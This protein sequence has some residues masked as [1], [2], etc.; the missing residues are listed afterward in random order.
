MT[1]WTV[2]KTEMACE[3]RVLQALAKLGVESF[4]PQKITPVRISRH[5]RKATYTESP[6]IARYIF[7]QCHPDDV[8]SVRYSEGP[9]RA[10]SGLA[11]SFPSK[12]ME[13]FQEAHGAWIEQQLMPF[14]VAKAKAMKP[15]PIRAEIV[16]GKSVSPFQQLADLFERQALDGTA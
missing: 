11:W 2:V 13:R 3:Y 9:V 4:I 14:T 5:T 7:V 12:T 16:A 10:K 8:P 15:K 6:L 1:Y